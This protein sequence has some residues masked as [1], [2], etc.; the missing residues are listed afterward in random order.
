MITQTGSTAGSKAP[1]PSQPITRDN[2][3]QAIRES[4]TRSR[5]V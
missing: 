2:L 1:P 5:G 4:L 3:A